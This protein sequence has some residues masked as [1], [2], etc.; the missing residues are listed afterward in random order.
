MI[1]KNKIGCA[2]LTFNSESYFEALF[3]SI[4]RS[5]LN[6]L[7]VVN[8]GDPYKRDYPNCHWIQHE[9]NRF[10][11]VCRND[12]VEK[13]L[14]LGCEHIFL[15]EDD[16]VLKNSDIFSKYIHHSQKTGIK[17]LQ[18][19]S[20][21]SG[22]GQVGNRTPV[23]IIEYPNGVFIHCYPNMCNEFT[24]H[25]ASV[26]D[27]LGN[28][29]YDENMRDAFDVELTWKESQMDHAMPFWYF[30]D[31][32]ESDSYIMNNPLAV[33][34]LQA[35]GAREKSIGKV[36]EYFEKKH[37]ISIPNI[38]RL[39]EAGLRDKVKS[40][41]SK[42]LLPEYDVFIPCAEKDFSKL[43]YVVNSVHRYLKPKQVYVCVPDDVYDQ[44]EV[45]GFTLIKDSDVLDPSIKESITFRPNWTYQQFLKMFQNVTSCDMF[46]TVD[47]DTIF[48]RSVD[49]FD[50]HDI[51]IWYYGASQNHRPYFALMEQEFSLKKEL[52]HTGIGE[53]GFFDKREVKRFLNHVNCKSGLELLER[54]APKLTPT[55][56]F[57]EFETYA[58]FS[59]DNYIFKQLHQY[60]YG[61]SIDDPKTVNWTGEE[62]QNLIT[63][64]E[65]KTDTLHLHSWKI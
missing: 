43:P 34:R 62:V 36:Y 20:T 3:D 60:S 57:S 61:R 32:P 21:S 24:Y 56:H 25:H 9:V 53:L 44:V 52:F 42:R 46:L 28:R 33:S 49:L 27:V 64:L 29:P 65:G 8:G 41:Y 30:A 59:R 38:P 5:T 35:N 4:D 22:S 2:I 7:V 10:P 51:P 45:K 50:R 23:K 1:I 31:I 26:F 17:Y 14:E 39:T 58:N 18:F 54:I 15:I 16:M 12:A 55:Y 37:G 48:C 63:A 19:A 40:M 11:S 13:L 47:A 6:E